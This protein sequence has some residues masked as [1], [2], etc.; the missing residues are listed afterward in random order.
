MNREQAKARIAH[1]SELIEEHNHKYY[2]LSAP[3]ISDYKFDMLL[4]ELQK[5]EKEYPEFLSPNS[6]SQ[7]VG[8]AVTKEFKTVK[9][10]YPMLS[11]ANTYSEEELIDFDNR[12]K[13]AIGAG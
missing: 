7:R 4:E 5:L 2:V 11:L 3:S 10:K 6:P 12:V 13:K 9:H 1:L 8:G